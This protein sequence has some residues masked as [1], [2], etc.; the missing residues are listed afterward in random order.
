MCKWYKLQFHNYETIKEPYEN[1]FEGKIC[2]EK[3]NKYRRCKK[4]GYTEKT[5]IIATTLSSCENK[6]LDG[7]IKRENGQ[8]VLPLSKLPENK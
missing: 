1:M 3:W 4:C 2:I 8:L 5:W 6:V 7:I